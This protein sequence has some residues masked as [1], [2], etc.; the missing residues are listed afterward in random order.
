[1]ESTA[2]TWFGTTHLLYG[3]LC[4]YLP[5]FGDKCWLQFIRHAPKRQ[6]SCR[7]R[8]APYGYQEEVVSGESSRANSLLECD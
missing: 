5:G 2:E 1:M 3:L 6:S 7:S 8:V 4:H